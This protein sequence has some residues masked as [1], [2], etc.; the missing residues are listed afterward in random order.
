VTAWPELPE[1]IRARILALVR[2]A[3]LGRVRGWDTGMRV[4]GLE[5]FRTGVG[6]EQGLIHRPEVSRGNGRTGNTFF[7]PG[8]I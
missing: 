1:A 6:V 3:S 4:D 2:A 5:D 8:W 7:L